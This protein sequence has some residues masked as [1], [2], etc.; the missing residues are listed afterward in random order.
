VIGNENVV[1]GVRGSAAMLRP[2]IAAIKLDLV[3]EVR[4]GACAD[5]AFLGNSSDVYSWT[6]C[7]MVDLD[8]FLFADVL[9]ER[10]GSWLLDCEA[11]WRA[12]LGRQCIDFE[13][14]IIEGPYKPAIARLERPIIVLH[15]GVFTELS[16]LASPP[17]KRWAW[18]KYTCLTEPGRLARLASPRPDLTEL[19]SG[20]KGVDYRLHAIASGTVTMSELILPSF[21]EEAFSVSLGDLNFVECCFAYALSCARNH[22]RVLGFGEAD[23][24]PNEKY[25][26]WYSE[27]VLGSEHLL[28]IV[29]IK[30][31]CRNTG[32]HV[33]GADPGR[34]LFEIAISDAENEWRI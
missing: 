14:R 26:Q 4:R 16:Y 19:L 11:R 9:D 33:D 21:L 6:P 13:L 34:A 27:N 15:L 29:Q 12:Q 8:V 2:V 23:S 25:V 24:L 7:F 5:L 31:R 3:E 30:A 22:G 1:G 10:L 17:L 32:F 28:Q 20:P 18:R